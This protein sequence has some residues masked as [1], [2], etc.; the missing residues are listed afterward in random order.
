M[1]TTCTL[2]FYALTYTHGVSDTM[3]SGFQ[4][5]LFKELDVKNN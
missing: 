5:L 4:F 2:Q 3:V 1:R